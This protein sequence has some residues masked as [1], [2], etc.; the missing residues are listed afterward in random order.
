MNSS[1]IDR[2]IAS[3]YYFNANHIDIPL[4][5]LKC[6][7]NNTYHTESLDDRSTL[8]ETIRVD[9]YRDVLSEMDSSAIVSE[10]PN[11]RHVCVNSKTEEDTRGIFR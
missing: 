2:S 1:S 7:H 4:H 9:N 6:F 10:Y 11:T 8:S 3:S 5:Q